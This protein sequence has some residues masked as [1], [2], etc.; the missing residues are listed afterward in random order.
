MWGRMWCY[1]NS[2][3]HNPTA[4]GVAALEKSLAVLQ[5]IKHRV[6]I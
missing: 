3:I 6:T 4:N 5:K 1:Q 2:P